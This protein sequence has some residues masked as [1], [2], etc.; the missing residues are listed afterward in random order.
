M[1]VLNVITRRVL[2]LAG[3]IY[4]L[5]IGYE[6]FL[7]LPFIFLFFNIVLFAISWWLFISYINFFWCNNDQGI[8]IKFP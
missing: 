2:I 1:K 3:V 6:S 4:V 7:G 5:F 8:V